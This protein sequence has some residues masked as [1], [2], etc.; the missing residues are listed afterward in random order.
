M[1]ASSQ[2]LPSRLRKQQVG[3][4]LEKSVQSIWIQEASLQFIA[5]SWN[6]NAGKSSRYSRWRTS[7][8]RWNVNTPTARNPFGGVIMLDSLSKCSPHAPAVTMTLSDL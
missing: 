4:H 2:S 5:S 6:D 1:A 8:F 7:N 3:I